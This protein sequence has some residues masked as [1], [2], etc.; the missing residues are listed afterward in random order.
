GG[1]ISRGIL[2]SDLQISKRYPGLGNEELLV[3]IHGIAVRHPGDEVPG[4]GVEALG[5]ENS[6]IQILGRLFSDALPQAAKDAGR[7]LE[8]GGRDVVL[9]NGLE[10][11]AAEP[12]CGLED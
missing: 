5:F 12:H 2:A 1:A 9:V 3:E 7:F 6:A 4:G 10:Q 8:L 11:K